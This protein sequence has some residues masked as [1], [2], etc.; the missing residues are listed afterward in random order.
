MFINLNRKIA[1][2]KV[3]AASICSISCAFI[4]KW[5]RS[6]SDL[7]YISYCQV[8]LVRR[9]SKVLFLKIRDYDAILIE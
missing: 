1:H 7:V 2:S 6:C 5:K 9:L 4:P 3:I 8:V